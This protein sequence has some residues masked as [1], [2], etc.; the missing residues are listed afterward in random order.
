MAHVYRYSGEE[1]CS[2]PETSCAVVE[3]LTSC[4][5]GSVVGEIYILVLGCVT[6]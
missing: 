2:Y 5:F 3:G 4:F 1:M 6:F